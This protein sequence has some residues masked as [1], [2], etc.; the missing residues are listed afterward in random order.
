MIDKGSQFIVSM[1]V[2]QFVLSHLSHAAEALQIKFI[3][4]IEF[5]NGY[6]VL[7]DNNVYWTNVTDCRWNKV[8]I[9]CL[10]IGSLL[11]FSKP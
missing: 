4:T 10:H 7:L 2:T 8:W 3:A 9:M 5:V 11:P 6:K 1:A